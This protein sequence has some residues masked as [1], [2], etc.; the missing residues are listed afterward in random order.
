[1][2]KNKENNN[3]IYFISGSCIFLDDFETVFFEKYGITDSTVELMIRLK[4]WRYNVKEFDSRIEELKKIKS[5]KWRILLKSETN[6]KT[7]VLNEKLKRLV[8]K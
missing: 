5:N 7:V 3:R 8:I 4:F 2:P 1:M 6:E